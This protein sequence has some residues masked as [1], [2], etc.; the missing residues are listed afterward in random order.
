MGE[1]KEEENKEPEDQRS[2]IIWSICKG[3]RSAGGNERFKIGTPAPLISYPAKT[4]RD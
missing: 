4:V 2:A 3:N 1:G